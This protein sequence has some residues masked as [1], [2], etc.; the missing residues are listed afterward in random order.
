MS[1]EQ[2]KP[3]FLGWTFLVLVLSAYGLIGIFNPERATQALTLFKHSLNQLLPVL[4]LV[5]FL[6]IIANLAIDSKRISSYVGKQSGL[7][8][9]GTAVIGGIISMGPVYAW[10]VLL[11]DLRRKEMRVALIATF[12]NSRAIKLPLLPLMIHYFGAAYT[13]VL[14]FYLIAFA[15][16]NG[17][18]IEKFSLRQHP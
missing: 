5:F 12:L 14:C 18:L 9:W 3:R 16:I 1:D 11:S 15:I 10:Y 6:L 7:K 17:W 2:P 4:G 8:G 13:A